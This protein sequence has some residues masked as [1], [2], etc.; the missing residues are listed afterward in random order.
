MKSSLCLINRKQTASFGIVGLMLT[1]VPL[2]LMLAKA[3]TIAHAQ[4]SNA[5]PTASIAASPGDWTQ[6]LRD[7]MQRYDPYEATIGVNNVGSLGLKWTFITDPLNQGG[8]S[9]PAVVKGVVY[10]GSQ[11]GH[12][13]ALNAAKGSKLWS[14]SSPAYIVSSPAVINGVVYIG[15]ANGALYAINAASGAEL[16]SFVS[17]SYVFGSPAVVS[18]VV[19]FGSIDGYVYALNAGTGAE[20]WRY[21]T[22]DT[23]SASPAVANGV[24]Y[25]SSSMGEMYALNAATGAEL[26]TYYIG[27]SGPVAASVTSA[28][29]VA[30]GVVYIDSIFTGLLY[31]L[32]ANS[33]KLLWSSPIGVDSSVAVANGVVYVAGGYYPNGLFE[34]RLYALNA[35]NGAELWT[36]TTG[37]PVESSPAVANGVVYIGSDDGNLYALDATTGIKLWSYATGGPGGSPVVANGMVYVGAREARNGNVAVLFA[38]G[39]GGGRTGAADLY[40]RVEPSPTPVKQGDLLSYT[41]PVWNLGPDNALR[42]V[43]STQVPAG[44]TFDYIRISGTPGLATCTHPSYQG[45]G[46]IVCR[47]NGSMAPNTTWTVRLTVRVTAASGTVITGN[48]ATLADTSDPNPTNNSATVSIKVQ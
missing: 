30:N 32:N 38:F 40:L 18:G 41:F 26:W 39:L 29:A 27:P 21:R 9:S 46:P 8:G 20:L 31:A 33:G 28:P 6:F 48:A 43:L 5:D 15:A 36:Y 12:V 4:A 47:E 11:D 17:G 35:I 14:F 37:A 19:Y 25:I 10:V 16:W 1:I 13:Y 7:N 42:E 23:V 22:P 3:S 44:T 34:G 24:V 2:W 45:I